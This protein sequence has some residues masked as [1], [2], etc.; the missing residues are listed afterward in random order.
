MRVMARRPEMLAVCLLYF[1]SGL[2]GLVYEVAFSKYLSYA[3]GAT[4]YASSAVLVAFMGGLSA[5]GLFVARW[6]ARLRNRLF[7]YGLV[8]ALVGAFCVA[9]PLLFEAI[10]WAYVALVRALP[11]STPVITLFRWLLATS[12]VFVPAAGMGA[13]LPLLAPLI[14]GGPSARRLSGPYTLN[15]MGG[16]SG[17]LFA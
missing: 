11:A 13:T 10:G 1:V 16:A 8:E 9:S 7:F 4:A 3:F 12:V 15:I 2:T 14:S 6:D 5:G 17:F